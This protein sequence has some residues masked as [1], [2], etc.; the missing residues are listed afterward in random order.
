VSITF[1]S[2]NTDCNN[3]TEYI[4]ILIDKNNIESAVF[5]LLSVNLLLVQLV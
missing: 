5:L 1:Y 3:V 2:A 4:M